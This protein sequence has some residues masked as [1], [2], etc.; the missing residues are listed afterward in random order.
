VAQQANHD[1]FNT[2][3]GIPMITSRMAALLMLTAGVATFAACTPADKGDSAAAGASAA[4]DTPAVA[5]PA[6]HAS[7]MS[8]AEG[9]S[10][11][12]DSVRVMMSVE[13]AKLVRADSAMNPHMAGEGHLH[14]FLDKDPTA[15]GA[16]I[17]MG[18]ASIVHIGSGASEWVFK[19]LS[20]GPHRIIAVYAFSDHTPDASVASDTVNII[21]R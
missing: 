8:P 17:P 11:S 3:R 20:K 14:L 4:A 21:V 15:A 19:K 7:I 9:D 16:P 2:I 13:G 12:G 10:V 1:P 6:P 18:D 5:A